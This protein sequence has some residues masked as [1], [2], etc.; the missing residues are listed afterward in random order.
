MIT[1]TYLGNAMFDL[2][3]GKIL[4][5]KQIE[6]IAL[7]SNIEQLEAMKSVCLDRLNNSKGSNTKCLNYINNKKR[8][9][10]LNKK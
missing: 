1:K 7:S 5:K 8:L 6:L 3:E 4:S 10:Y 9:N 2:F